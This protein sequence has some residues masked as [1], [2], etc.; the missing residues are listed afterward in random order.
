MNDS[1]VGREALTQIFFK[2]VGLR[3]VRTERFL[4]TR[5][6]YFGAARNPVSS[7]LE[8]L[9]ALG[10]ECPWRFETAEAILVGSE[11]SADEWTQRD[12]P[13]GR[14]SPR[15]LTLVHHLLEIENCDGSWDTTDDFVVSSLALDLFGGMRIGFSGGLC[16]SLFPASSESMQWILMLPRPEGAL[17]MMRGEVHRTH[18]RESDTR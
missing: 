1:V 10:V 15:E 3:L 2:L 6:F 12:R 7:P 9:Y 11:D 14:A 4:G 17:V 13:R 8:T 18:G 16:L 5:H